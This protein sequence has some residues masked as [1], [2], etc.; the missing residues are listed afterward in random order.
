MKKLIIGIG[1]V[2]SLISFSAFAA[3]EE[4]VSPQVLR[5]FKA[6]FINAANVKWT[7]IDE[8]YAVDF[9]QNGFRVEA[10]FDDAGELLGTSRNIMFN[11]LPLA[12]N[13]A[14]CERFKDAPVYE[15]FEYTV[16]TE[17]FY[18]MKVEVPGKTLIVR[19]GISGSTMI[20]KR[21]R[22]KNS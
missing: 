5:A 18:K 16:G 3:G 14:L 11:E 13:V 12:V 6:E 17:T 10:Y 8:I 4:E 19:S 2:L 22:H 20:E 1:L 7:R 21:I 9:T 15:I